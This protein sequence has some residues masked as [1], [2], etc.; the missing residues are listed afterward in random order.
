VGDS[1]E[2]VLQQAGAFLNPDQMAAL[3]TVLANGI[4]ARTT[5]AA[6]FTQKHLTRLLFGLHVVRLSIDSMTVARY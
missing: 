5:Q 4:T 6:A 2:R 1:N 3:K